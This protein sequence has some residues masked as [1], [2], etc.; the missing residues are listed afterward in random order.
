MSSANTLLNVYGLCNVSSYWT[1]LDCAK[2]IWLL[3]SNAI[4]HTAVVD[5]TLLSIVSAGN[6]ISLLTLGVFAKWNIVSKLYL[7]FNSSNKVL[8]W[9]DDRYYFTA[10]IVWLPGVRKSSTTTIFAWG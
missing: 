3:C 10:L 8:S 7:V 4:S 1:L 9:I 6:S 5:V 2:N